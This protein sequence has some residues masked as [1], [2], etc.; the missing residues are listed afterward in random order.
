MEVSHLKPYWLFSPAFPLRLFARSASGGACKKICKHTSASCKHGE[1]C[2]CRQEGFLLLLLVPLLGLFSLFFAGSLDSI[3]RAQERDALQARVDVCAVR[4]ALA[5]ER[6][7]DRLASWN[8][9]LL[10][11]VTGIYVARGIRVV[12]GPVGAGIGGTAEAALLKLNHSLAR[13]QEAAL[14]AATLQEAHGVSCAQNDFSR[15]LAICKLS[16]GAR[17]SVRRKKTLFP[18]VQGAL[19]HRKPSAALALISCTGYPRRGA[20]LRT[21]LQ[22]QGDP[23]LTKTGFRDSYAE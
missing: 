12:G 23:A 1:S 3:L 18:D 7:L 20:A 5:R 11:T 19:T 2:A 6:L 4:L 8:Q 22:I 17:G 9:A 10:L 15:G 13:L 21:R 14:V 16:P